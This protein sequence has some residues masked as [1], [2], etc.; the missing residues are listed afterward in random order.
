[1]G[2]G[3]NDDSSIEDQQVEIKAEPK[4]VEVDEDNSTDRVLEDSNLHFNPFPPFKGNRGAFHKEKGS[5]TSGF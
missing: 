3:I 5:E 1:M 4:E 2:V